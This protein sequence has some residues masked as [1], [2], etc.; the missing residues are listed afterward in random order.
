MKKSFMEK[1]DCPK[2]G[3][4]MEAVE[5][6]TG[7]EIACVSCGE[8]FIAAGKVAPLSPATNN[9]RETIRRN[10]R[11]I[12]Y[13]A[14]T[15][16]VIVLF[17]FIGAMAEWHSDAAAA[18]GEDSA[19]YFATAYWFLK[20]AKPK[21]TWRNTDGQ[22]SDSNG[23]RTSGTSCAVLTTLIASCKLEP[24]GRFGE[25]SDYRCRSILARHHHGDGR[26]Q[27]VHVEWLVIEL[28]IGRRQWLNSLKSKTLYENLLRRIE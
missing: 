19:P 3:Q 13:F 8:K 24:L 1:F 22:R 4:P 15:L 23:Y 25:M 11:L 26:L 10:A 20:A 21:G 6:V 7:Q 28:Y 14:G 5:D 2:C 17:V 9:N 18:H 27:I 12:W 16:A